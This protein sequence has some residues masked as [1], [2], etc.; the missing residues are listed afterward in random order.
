MILSKWE[1]DLEE[2]DANP[3]IPPECVSRVSALIRLVRE[4]DLVLEYYAGHSPPFVSLDTGYIPAAGKAK[5]ALAL[6]KELK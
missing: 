2:W 6:T 1:K 5:Q 4:K 3:N